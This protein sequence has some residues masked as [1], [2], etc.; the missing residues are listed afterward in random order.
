MSFLTVAIEQFAATS[1]I[2]TNLEQVLEAVRRGAKGGARVI[3]LPE[4]SMLPF[5]AALNIEEDLSG[6]WAMAV[7]D[8]AASLGVVVCVGLFQ[9]GRKL[10]NTLLVTG[11]ELHTGYDKIHL[12]DAFGYRESDQICAGNAIKVISLDGIGLGLAIC[13]DLRFPEH[14]I[15]MAKEGAHVM[16]VAAQWADGAG[17]LEQWRLLARA[18]ALDSTSWLLACGQAS[19]GNGFGIGHSMIVSPMGEIVAEL[20]REKGELLASIDLGAVTQAREILPVLQTRKNQRMSR[21]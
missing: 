13:Y 9:G 16:L 12:Y 21:S 8:L 15:H 1:S 2:E 7:H 18:R 20:G 3:L 17:K 4:A 10:R 14:F 5:G 6:P 19:S 11:K